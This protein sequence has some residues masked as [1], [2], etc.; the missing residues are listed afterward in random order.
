VPTVPVA[1]DTATAAADNAELASFLAFCPPIISCLISS[2]Y[3]KFPENIIT[4]ILLTL[5]PLTLFYCQ[6]ALITTFIS[7]VI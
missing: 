6:A 2:I 7:I 3:N 4:K 1:I 5:A